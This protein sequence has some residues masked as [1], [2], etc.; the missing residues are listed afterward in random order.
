MNKILILIG[1][2]LLLGGLSNC[3][4]V[5]LEKEGSLI[6]YDPDADGDNKLPN[7]MWGWVG[8]YPGEVDMVTDRLDAV[9]VVV[10]GYEAQP[11]LNLL[12]TPKYWQSSGL[13]IAPAEKIEVIVPAGVIGKLYY[14]IGVADIELSENELG[15]KRYNKVG[16]KGELALGSNTLSNN[17]GGHLYFYYE[18]TPNV[19]NVTL[20]VNGAVKSPDFIKGQTD[21]EEWTIAV[22][23]TLTPMIWGE[24]I[25]DNITLTLPIEEL[26]TIVDP[27]ALL[28]KY[29]GLVADLG[30]LWVGE[31][32]GLFKLGGIPMWRVYGDLHLPGKAITYPGYPAGLDMANEALMKALKEMAGNATLESDRNFIYNVLGAGYLTAWTKDG[33]LKSVVSGL[34]TF[35][36]YNSANKW[37]SNFDV[38]SL[39]SVPDIAKIDYAKLDEKYKQRMVLQLVQEFGWGLLTYVNNE[40]GSDFAPM[41]AADAKSAPVQVN[42]DW[43]AIV[44]SEY[45]N[46][47]MT[48][49]FRAWNFKLTSSSLVYMAKYAAPATEFWKEFNLD[50]PE[51]DRGLKAHSFGRLDPTIVKDTVYLPEEWVGSASS[52]HTASPV[53]N[54]LDGIPFSKDPKKVKSGEVWHNDWA[55]AGPSQYFPHSIWFNFDDKVPTEHKLEFNYFVVMQH[56]GEGRDYVEAKEAQVAIWKDNDWVLIEDEKVFFL[57]KAD[58]AQTFYLNQS[59]ETTAVKL[60]LLNTHADKDGVYVGYDASGNPVPLKH[61]CNLGEFR[62]GLI[63]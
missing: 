61:D 52:S 30:K 7:D 27:E 59:Y 8:A 21:L 1:S 32:E 63:K 35:Y 29:D 12:S 28:T 55:T 13:Y 44:V 34:S 56:G 57:D 26:R 36:M 5:E 22:Q 58:G 25:G 11:E 62:V 43:F 23:N 41:L 9:S 14:Q 17:F 6:P 33:A 18:G 46:L 19:A 54:L 10:K 45:A 53:M 37:P 60:I 47:N 40:L 2:I 50:M 39:T 48:N 31:T 20:T 49:F 15:L 16:K 38:T 4:D 51:L 24:L 42:N 3:S